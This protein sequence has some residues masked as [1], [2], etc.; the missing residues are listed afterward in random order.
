MLCPDGE[1]HLRL[2]SASCHCSLDRRLFGDTSAAQLLCRA[3]RHQLVGVY[4]VRWPEREVSNGKIVCLVNAQHNGSMVAKDGPRCFKLQS[5][6][7]KIFNCA[8]TNC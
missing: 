2:V 3:R 8:V 7:L 6:C 1:R 4:R 5:F